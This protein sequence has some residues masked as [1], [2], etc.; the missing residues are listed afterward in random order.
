MK[1]NNS[2]GRSLYTFFNRKWFFDKVYTEAVTQPTMH[3]SYHTTY[4]MV[5]RGLIELMGPHGISQ[6]LYRNSYALSRFQTGHLYH[7]TLMMIVGLSLPLFFFYAIMP[8]GIIS[9]VSM[10]TLQFKVIILFFI[11]TVL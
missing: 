11:L 1:T 4:K 3:H 10:S 8:M 5:D 2:L 6:T 9:T 7:Y